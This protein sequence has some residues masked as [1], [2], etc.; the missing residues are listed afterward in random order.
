MK[1][2]DAAGSS[3]N[4]DIILPFVYFGARL[5]ILDEPTAALGVKQSGVVL[6]YTAAAGMPA[7]A[8]SSS[9][10]THTTPTSSGTTS[11]S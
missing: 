4:I 8:W 11:L 3:A 7:S 5:L 9:P 10:T 2:K 6:K 1:S